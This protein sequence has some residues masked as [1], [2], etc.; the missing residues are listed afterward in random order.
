MTARIVGTEVIREEDVELAYTLKRS[1][2]KTLAITVSPDGDV[3]VTAPNSAGREAIRSRVRK[4]LGWI[5]DKRREFEALRPRTPARRYL[6]GE[7]HRHLGRQYR[8]KFDPS[9]PHG[10]N[11]TRDRI[12]IGGENAA[13]SIAAA[14]ALAVWRREQAKAVFA[15]RLDAMVERYHLEEVRRPKLLVRRLAKRWGSLSGSPATLVLNVRLIEADVS[16]IDYVIAHELTHDTH[17]DHG[18]AFQGLLSKRMPDWR[19]R[20]HRLERSLL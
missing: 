17:S 2:R 5:S 4:R 16:L 12:V 20:K 18:P 14:K 13:S 19:R 7:T 3:I 10:V 6:G 1:S 11:L 15:E 8:L 9:A